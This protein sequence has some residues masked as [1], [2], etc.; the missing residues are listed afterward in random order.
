MSRPLI[1]YTT[2]GNPEQGRHIARE[3]VEARLAA[4]VTCQPGLISFYRWAGKVEED[5][6]MLLLIKT[7]SDRLDALR[8]HLLR[9]HPYE[10]PELLVVEVAEAGEAYLHWLNQSVSANGSSVQSAGPVHA[11][12]GS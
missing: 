5:A 12:D 10:V 11:G 7:N 2:V 8:S 4:C 9:L 3:L 1:V 6:E